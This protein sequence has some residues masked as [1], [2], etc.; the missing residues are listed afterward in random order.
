MKKPL[1]AIRN[2]QNR[3]SVA[4]ERSK[5]VAINPLD[6][7][8][9]VFKTLELKPLKW[10]GQISVL[11]VDDKRIRELN[12]KYLNKN[13][14]TDVLAFD[15]SRGKGDISCEIIVSCDTAFYNSSIYKTTPVY[16]AYLYVIHGLLHILGYDDQTSGE[17]KTM[18][19]K[20]EQILSTLTT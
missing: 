18:Q 4:D 5:S 13:Y 15:L 19:K 11:L 9:L 2:L 20:A 10:S 17:Q 1:V 14:P 12:H 16:E 8:K 3:I 7:K 6:I